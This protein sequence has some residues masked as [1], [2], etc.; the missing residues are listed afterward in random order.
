MEESIHMTNL[1]HSNILTLIGVCVDGGPSPFI[2]TPFMDNGS[3]L[4]YLKKKRDEIILGE[5]A[6][7][8]QVSIPF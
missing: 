5:G 3:L 6:D 7:E 4:S 1:K 2:V 8:D